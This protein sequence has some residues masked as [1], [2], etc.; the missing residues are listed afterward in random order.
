MTLNFGAGKSEWLLHWGGPKCQSFARMADKSDKLIAAMHH[1]VKIC[2]SIVSSYKHLG[3]RFTLSSNIA[4]EVA[5]RAAIINAE[6]KS[7]SGQFLKNMNVP[8]KSKTTVIQAYVL[9]KGAYNCGTWP[10]LNTSQYKKFHTAFMNLY[11]R[12]SGNTYGSGEMCDDNEVIQSSSFMCPMT[13]IRH[14]RLQLFV[15]IISKAPTFMRNLIHSLA[16]ISGSWAF[17][18]RRDLHWFSSLNSKGCEN[19]DMTAWTQTVL[20]DPNGFSSDCR[21]ICR[22][23][24]AN[25]HAQWATT[26]AIREFGMSHWCDLCSV[27]F[28]S[29]Q[30]LALH[31]YKKHGVKNDVRRLVDTTHCPVCMLQFWTRERVI[32]H[33]R[34]RST[35]CRDHLSL[36]PKFSVEY[37][38]ELDKAEKSNHASLAAGG[39]RRHSSTRP[40]CRLPGP[41]VPIIVVH[42]FCN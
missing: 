32:N 37:A 35:L 3:T 25:V 17:S 39:K 8:F 5:V 36:F 16:H 22:S 2:M 24:Y 1:D 4:H 41:L 42:R 15:R 23:A 11:R 9:S 30:Q 34:Y 20:D 14:A 33:L 29:R 21:R 13:L 26:K 31:S 28:G 19:Y 6:S 27:A 40:C 7:L 10:L 12:A 18:L 38:E